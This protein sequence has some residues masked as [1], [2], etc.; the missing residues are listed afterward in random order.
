MRRGIL[1]PSVNW[2]TGHL[3]PDP[4]GC[5]LMP[6]WTGPHLSSTQSKIRTCSFRYFQGGGSLCCE[7]GQHWEWGG[8]GPKWQPKHLLIPP[9]ICLAGAGRSSQRHAGT[10]EGGGRFP[11]TEEFRNHSEEFKSQVCRGLRSKYCVW[12]LLRGNTWWWG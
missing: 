10:L 7:R 3:W 12:G 6:V 4:P 5:E 8:L 11:Q 1:V 9:D 2:P